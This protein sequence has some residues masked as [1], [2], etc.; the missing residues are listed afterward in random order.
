M[1]AM[2]LAFLFLYTNNAHAAPAPNC[3]A[4]GRVTFICCVTNVEDFAPAPDT[5]SVIG[6]DLPTPGSPQGNLYLFESATR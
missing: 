1:A 4:A 6:S 5:K 3:S 2:A